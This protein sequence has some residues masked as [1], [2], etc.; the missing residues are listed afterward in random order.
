MQ[1]V[2]MRRW[3]SRRPRRPGS[4]PRWATCCLLGGLISGMQAGMSG[5]GAFALPQ[6]S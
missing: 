4:A 5:S 1:S 6:M 2:L 3:R